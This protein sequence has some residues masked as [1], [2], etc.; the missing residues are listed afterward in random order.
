M[1]SRPLVHFRTSVQST[2]H[3]M[4]VF[5]PKRVLVLLLFLA[6]NVLAQSGS[7]VLSFV[8]PLIGTVNG[9]H[10]FPGATL[11]FGMAKAVAD[12]NGEDQGG[13][14]SDGSNITGFSHM[15]DSGTGGVSLT[16]LLLS[17]PPSSAEQLMSDMYTALALI[18]CRRITS[19]NSLHKAKH[20]TADSIE[21]SPSLGNFPIF[22]QAGCPDEDINNCV[23]PKTSRATPRINGTVEASPGYFAIEL[24]TNIK[25]EM[26]VTNHT[27]LYRFT[28]PERPTESNATLSPLIL[29]DLSDLPNS[30]INGSISVDDSTGRITGNGTFSPSFGIGSYTLHFCADFS[31]AAVRDTGV[32]MNDRAGTEPKNLSVVPDGLNNSPE[33]LPAGAWTR[34][35][36]PTNGSHHILARV[37]VSFISVARAC[38]N[39]ETEIPTFDFKAVR[40]AAQHAWTDTLSPISITPGSGVNASMQ[41]VFW[42]GVYRASISPQ[43]Y[44]GENPLWQSSEPYYDSYYCIWDSFR[45]IHSLIT[46]VD[47]VSQ[48]RMMQS[49]IDIYRHEGWLPDCRMSLCKGFTQGGS[50]A[51]VVLTDTFLKL[52]SIAGGVDWDTAYEALRTDAEDEPED[53]GVQGRGGLTSWKNLHYV[54][55]DDY[56]PYGVGLFTRSISRTV[57]YAYDDFCVAEMAQGLGNQGDAEKYY[58]RA[59]YWR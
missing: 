22:P 35:H 51:D 52:K 24:A 14:S 4:A 16:V 20:S 33:I 48:I 27:A 49:L 21:Q 9:G 43:D 59:E 55:T 44:T 34:F 5:E 29:A 19:S 50:N 23:F 32:F 10:V 36:A 58:G 25:A 18:P 30:R 37:G 54:P 11:P 40:N 47:P 38:S 12:V 42:S 3:K 45:S 1:H 57:E 7:N 15:H 56:D 41:T 46:I 31:G 2:S 13:F 53:W 6:L 26:T 28:F 8:D 39:A 17:Y